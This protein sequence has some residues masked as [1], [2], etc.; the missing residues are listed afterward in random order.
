[1]RNA[2]TDPWASV[3]LGFTIFQNQELLI[4]LSGELGE[5]PLSLTARLAWIALSVRARLP[6]NRE[7]TKEDVARAMGVDPRTAHRALEELRQAGLAERNGAGYCLAVPPS[8]V[9]LGSTGKA[10]DRRPPLPG[11]Q[12]VQGSAQR[13]HQPLQRLHEEGGEKPVQEPAS[14]GSKIKIKV[15]K[16]RSSSHT[17]TP[18]SVEEEEGVKAIPSEG[19]AKEREP[20]FVQ[21]PGQKDLSPQREEAVVAV[22]TR[23]ETPDG[24]TPSQVTEPKPAPSVPLAGSEP[25][26][27]YKTFPAGRVKPG[28][29]TLRPV[30]ER[31]GLWEAF[32]RYLR[33]TVSSGPAWSGFMARLEREALPLGDVFLQAL[34]LTL[35]R[36]A[37]GVVRYP[38]A[39]LWK[40][41]E[42]ARSL[43]PSP[44]GP[45][46]TPAPV[47][48]EDGELLRL[49]DGRVGYFAGWTAG[50]AKGFLEVEGTSY[51]LPR[52]LLLQA[53]VLA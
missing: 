37:L 22:E 16:K 39:Y 1:M 9:P 51:V 15:K 28:T 23:V 44:G 12:A 6:F 10:A 40:L 8:G 32:W 49:P 41:L 27:P 46:Q 50:G 48:L 43:A 53:E 52:E 2:Q 7:A 13:L 33:P 17:H 24:K 34:A 29:R 21:A 31:A 35:E 5:K 20:G 47:H 45:A 26:V 19:N 18:G 30:L 42:N 38:V 25:S 14:R 4:V 3:R 11:K 36:T